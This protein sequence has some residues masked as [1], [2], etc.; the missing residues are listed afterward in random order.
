M[1]NKVVDGRAVTVPAQVQK[2][3]SSALAADK[4]PQFLLSHA[5]I[6]PFTAK[7]V[8]GR[9]READEVEAA[10]AVE[11]IAAGIAATDLL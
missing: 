3:R 8:T 4:P 1:V 5:E 2:Q 6:A 7:T 9:S 10:A 11:E